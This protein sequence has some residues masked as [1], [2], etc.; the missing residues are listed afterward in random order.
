MGDLVVR[1][2]VLAV[3]FR[4]FNI[5]DSARFD[6]WSATKSFTALAFGIILYDPEYRDKITMDSHA[7]DFIP[8]GHPLTDERKKD[9]TVGHRCR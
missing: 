7:Y 9:I 6:V 5:L 8:E 1:H 2:G 3:E 4:T